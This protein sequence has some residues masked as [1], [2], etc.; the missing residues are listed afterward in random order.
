M[1]AMSPESEKQMFNGITL[2]DA[3]C[4]NLRMLFSNDADVRE[5]SLLNLKTLLSKVF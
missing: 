4:A 5:R 3:V 2:D 1:H